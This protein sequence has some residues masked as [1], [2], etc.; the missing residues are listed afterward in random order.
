MSSSEAR[1]VLPCSA[2]TSGNN[3]LHSDVWVRIINVHTQEQPLYAA[4]RRITNSSWVAVKETDLLSDSVNVCHVSP[5]VAFCPRPSLHSVGLPRSP[6]VHRSTLRR[7]DS[8]LVLRPSYISDLYTYRPSFLL[9]VGNTA[10]SP[11][12][13]SM[14]RPLPPHTPL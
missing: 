9:L 1:I 10:P 13:R 5:L 4:P 6:V 11:T 8:Q 7:T 2:V 12:R 3:A 14:T